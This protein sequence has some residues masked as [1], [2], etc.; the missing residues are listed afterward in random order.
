MMA[1]KAAGVSEAAG[2]RRERARRTR[3][4]VLIGGIALVGAVSGFMIGYLDAESLIDPSRTW[5]P[6]MA[7]GLAFAYLAAVL[8]GGLALARQ[9]D[10]LELSRQYKAIAAAAGLYVLAYPVWFFLWKGTLLPEPGHELLFIL[11]WLG[12]AGASLFYR[13]R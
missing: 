9:T 4:A 7:I 11:F 2:E 6:A 5:P 10:E 13:F 3:K 1:A 12:M 8:G